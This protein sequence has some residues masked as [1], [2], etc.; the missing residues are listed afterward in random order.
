MDLPLVSDHKKVAISAIWRI[1]IHYNN[2]DE[3]DNLED[4]ADQEG[5][6]VIITP[7]ALVTVV[8]V[9]SFYSPRLIPKLQVKV[10][11]F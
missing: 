10:L 5:P 7:K 6:K 2:D 1:Q 11:F 3:F 9:D 8:R 4:S